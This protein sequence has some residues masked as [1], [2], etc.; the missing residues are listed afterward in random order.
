MDVRTEIESMTR[1]TEKAYKY[2]LKKMAFT[3]GPVELKKRMDE[4]PEQIQ[5]VD[6]RKAEDYDR[7]HIPGAISMPKTELESGMRKLDKNKITVVYCYS[8]QCH[9]AASCAIVLAQ[10]GYPVMELE[11]GFKVWRDDF[12]MDVTSM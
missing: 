5:I 3:L 1:N 11:G 9:L 7:S 2:F 10:N 6:L 12:D 8:Q 4:E